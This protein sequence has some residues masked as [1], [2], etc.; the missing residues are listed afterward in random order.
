V[1]RRIRN[2]DFPSLLSLPFESHEQLC[3]AGIMRTKNSEGGPQP[4][5]AESK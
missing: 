3:E 5:L 2:A 4:A 1:R